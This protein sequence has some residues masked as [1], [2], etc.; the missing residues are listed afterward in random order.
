MSCHVFPRVS[1][2][3]EWIL[4]LS[5]CFIAVTF[6]SSCWNCSID[7][8]FSDIMGGRRVCMLFLQH[9]CSSRHQMCLCP[10]S[11]PSDRHSQVT[12]SHMIGILVERL[13]FMTK[14]EWQEQQ[15]S[16]ATYVWGTIESPCP[17]M[18]ANGSNRLVDE[19]RTILLLLGGDKITVIGIWH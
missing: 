5:T 2:K 17:L 8:D 4:W 12:N 19:G 15:L 9:G 16:R 13:E 6:Q 10:E 18:V 1:S 11:I 3:Y 7:A 14:G